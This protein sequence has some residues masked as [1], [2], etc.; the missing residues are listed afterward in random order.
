MDGS[1][2]CATTNDILNSRQP[3]E[4]RAHRGFASRIPKRIRFHGF[5][6]LT[7]PIVRI[8]GRCLTALTPGGAGTIAEGFEVAAG[9]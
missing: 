9:N 5:N 8:N 6:P 7:E 2:T 3:S 1:K 4:A